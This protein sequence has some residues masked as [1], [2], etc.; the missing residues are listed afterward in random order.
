M[1][2]LAVAQRYFA[3]WNRRDPSAVVETFVE[4]GT[5]SDPTAPSG[6][7]GAAIAQ[8]VAGLLT[9][10]PDLSFEIVSAAPTGDRSVAAQWLMRGTNTGPLPGA[11]PTGRTVALPG[12]DF[13]VTAGDKVRSVHGYF[14]QRTFVEQL[15]LQVAIVPPS[16]GPLAFG[17]AVYFQPGT[18]AKPGAISVTAI[19]VRSQDEVGRVVEYSRRIVQEVAQMPG[20]LGFVGATVGHRLMT[21]TAWD[22]VERPAQLLRGGTHGEAMQAFFGSDFAAGGVTGVWVP[23]HINTMWVRCGSCGRMADARQAACPCGTPLPPHPAYW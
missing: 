18:L 8:Y 17:T 13:I 15:G 14:D 1:E 20:F 9:A 11:P 21:V 19:Q 4:D 7:R 10:F 6:L 22:N 12:A 3:A 23:H 2:A 5:Y 16:A